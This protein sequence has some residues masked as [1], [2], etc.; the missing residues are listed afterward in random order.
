[1]IFKKALSSK[2]SKYLPKCFSA[3]Q[4][5]DLLMKVANNKSE[6]KSHVKTEASF[7]DAD[8]V[9]NVPVVM[10]VC[11]NNRQTKNVAWYAYT[12]L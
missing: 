7:S 11:V 5:I 6:N 3:Q 10:M 4:A 2:N 8:K 9:N 1:V 12:C